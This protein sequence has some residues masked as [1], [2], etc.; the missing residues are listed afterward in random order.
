MKVIRR[1]GLKGSPRAENGR[2]RREAERGEKK[3]ILGR[4]TA[5]DEEKSG[6]LERTEDNQR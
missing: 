3:H 4:G 2:V 1:V 6:K 5:W